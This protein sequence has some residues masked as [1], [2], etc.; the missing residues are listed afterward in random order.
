MM[1]SLGNHFSSLTCREWSGLGATYP[2]ID[3]RSSELWRTLSGGYTPYNIIVDLNGQVRYASTGFNETAINTILDT[4]LATQSINPEQTPVSAKLIS[5]Y[6]NPFNAGTR[7]EF[8]LDYAEAVQLNIYDATG[9]KVKTL[10]SG[11]HSEGQHTLRWNGDN[12]DG[13][14]ISSGIYLVRLQTSES[15]SSKKIL[16]LK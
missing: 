15:S 4:L 3:D 12:D 5:A 10:H 8:E 6:P 1:I 13:R 11:F 2:I 7:I 14:L 16:Y 9:R